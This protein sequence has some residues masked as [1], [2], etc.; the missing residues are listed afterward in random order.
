MPPKSS[1]LT[2]CSSSTLVH[3]VCK[4]I[5]YCNIF[6]TYNYCIYFQQQ[7]TD[8]CSADSPLFCV[9]TLDGFTHV[10]GC[11]AQAISLTI[12]KRC[13]PKSPPTTTQQDAV[14][15]KPPN[16]H[17]KSCRSSNYNKR[18]S[19]GSDQTN[20]WLI[21]CPKPR[22]YVC[23]IIHTPC[24]RSLKQLLTNYLTGGMK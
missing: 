16:S 22:H 21:Q 5:G 20:S 6:S 10:V 9:W 11:V 7:K 18:R 24:C 13:Y 19:V 3:F 1:I 4:S 2:D 17:W 15:V 8:K 12:R 14:Q 23:R